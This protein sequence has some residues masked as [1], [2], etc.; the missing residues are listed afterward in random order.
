MATSPAKV[1]QGPMLPP[2]PRPQNTRH[3]KH[4]HEQKSGLAPQSV[5][6]TLGEVAVPLVVLGIVMA[7][8]TPLPSFMLDLLISMNITISTI[9]LL[10]SLYIT[11]P[12]EFSVFP[13]ALLL[14]TLFRLALNVSSA[15]LILLNGNSGT[16]AA[17]HVIEA[18]GNF[19]V[20]GNYI[21]GV[22]IFLV[23]IAIQYVVIN[24]GAVR[25]SEVTAR[26][27]LDAMPGKQMSIDSDLNA[28]LID[29][30][31]AKARRKGL[32][33]EA[34][35]YGAMDGASRFTQRDAVASI[36]ITAI[37]IIAGFLIGVLQHGMD[38]TRAIQTYTVLTIGD[39][40]VTVI[41]ALMISISG[42]LIVTRASSDSKLSADVR[43]QVFSNPQPLLLAAGVLVAMAAFPGLPKVPF[44]LIGTTLGTVAWRMRQKTDT[45]DKSTP[46]AAAPPK[47]NLESLLK[48]EAL[49]VEVGLGLVKLV[50]GGANSPLLRRIGGIRRQLATDLGYL[51]PPV[52]VMDN[53]GLKVREY[54][55]S[56]KGV[57]VSRYELPQGCELAISTARNAP[58]IDGMPT[59]EPAFG[60]AAVWIPSEKAEKARKSGYT[61]V[62]G[63]SV[64]GTH[65]SEVIRK[66]AHELFSRADTKKVLD[67]VTEENPK[68]VEDLVPKLLSLAIVQRVL[69]NLLRERVSIRDANTIVE[70]L[71]EGAGITRNPVLL[72]EYVRQA[73]RRMVVKPYLN[74]NGDLAAFFFDPALEQ[75]VESAVEHNDHTSHINLAPQ[76]IRNVLDRISRT[77]GPVENPMVAVS[78]SGARFFMRQLVEASIPNLTILSHSEIPTGVKVI[79]LGVIQ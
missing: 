9:V 46:S 20:G 68:A 45:S 27:T 76:S 50:E 48:V 63:V 79:S 30:A 8:I 21:I 6:S 10:V 23:L 22:V 71:G 37:N 29:E 28:G 58:P 31:E 44:L 70:A 41:P 14:L 32:A 55:I 15:R 16:A 51:L 67:R 52:R 78:G 49:A 24:H 75:M 38:L 65:L 12:V 1:S 5:L 60:I 47:E 35:F 62:D 25:I 11:R 42:G 64:L 34:E 19:V 40:L 4:R 18:F 17:G 39:G 33:A 77:L 73:I 61:V 57:E 69:Q 54:I 56:I 74:A 53:L 7:M 26:F 2:N 36:I 59:R 66:H 13:T 3:A 43:T 72:T